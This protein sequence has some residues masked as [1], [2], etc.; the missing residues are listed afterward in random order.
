MSVPLKGCVRGTT[1][2]KTSKAVHIL[3]FSSHPCDWQYSQCITG[4]AI[5]EKKEVAFFLLPSP[6][7]C[8]TDIQALTHDYQHTSQ[9]AYSVTYRKQEPKY[10]VGAKCNLFNE[11]SWHSTQIKHERRG[12]LS[13]GGWLLIRC[14]LRGFTCAWDCLWTYGCE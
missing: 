9:N 14:G 11:L 7:L 6:V 13:D 1:T 2:T 12:T 3:Q 5:A 4:V 8:I 10:T